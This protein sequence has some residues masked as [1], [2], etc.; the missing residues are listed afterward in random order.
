[1]F[2]ACTG[3]LMGD[4]GEQKLLFAI[5]C[6]SVSSNQ[7]SCIK[8]HWCN[9]PLEKIGYF[10][11]I[12]TFQASKI[13]LRD[14]RDT[15]VAPKRVHDQPCHCAFQGPLKGP[16]DFRDSERLCLP[17]LKK[18]ILLTIWTSWHTFMVIVVLH[19]VSGN[20]QEPSWTP[21]WTLKLT[22]RG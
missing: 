20:P 14:S 6:V 12:F 8:C 4:P 17:F 3:T 16:C 18:Y 2:V 10:G 1:M 9:G 13:I 5:E 21:K 7:L 15:R 19:Q 22:L 11:H